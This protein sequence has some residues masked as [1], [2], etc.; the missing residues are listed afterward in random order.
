MKKIL[1]IV[2]VL[3]VLWFLLFW[4]F[5]LGKWRGAGLFPFPRLASP[6]PVFVKDTIEVVK[7]KEKRTFVDR[8]IYKEAKVETVYIVKYEPWMDSIYAAITFDKQGSK[9]TVVSKLQKNVRKQ[10]FTGVPNNFKGHGTKEGFVLDYKRF[11]FDWV[12]W[13][14][15]R[16]GC[17][18]YFTTN[19]DPL[20]Y[21]KT[22]FDI[23]WFTIYAGIDKTAPFWDASFN[24]K[25][26]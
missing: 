13:R 10:V 23:K 24:L 2:G 21:A 17:K 5:R 16:I 20:P 19:F 26:W 9:A 12:E 22:G 6:F 7:I 8:I 14:G 3:F 25:F 4:T 11:R 18:N 15:I 1:I